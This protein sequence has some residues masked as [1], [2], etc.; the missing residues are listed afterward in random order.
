M[1]YKLISLFVIILTSY[2][3]KAQNYRQNTSKPFRDL[4]VLSL[5]TGSTFGVTDYNKTKVG[6]LFLGNID[7]YF[8][9]S[10]RIIWSIGLKGSIN[11]VKGIGNFLGFPTNFN[12]KSFA[13]GTVFRFNYMLSESYFPYLSMGISNYRFN[14]NH[15]STK[16]S[17]VDAT[18]GEN[19]TSIVF[20]IESG[21]KIQLSEF[22]GLNIGAG[23]HF[24][25][26]DNLDAVAFGKH[27]DYF[28]SGNNGFSISLI[29][30]KDSDGDGILDVYDMC[31]EEAEDFDGYQD[32]DGCPDYDNDHDG[33][34]DSVDNCP[35]T[36][37]DL[38]GYEDSDGCPE[39]DND[40]D[41]ILDKND[42]CPDKAEDFDG[43]KDFDGCPDYDNDKD[44]IPDSL[45]K[46]PNIPEN[47]NGYQDSD[48][49][50]DVK[51]YTKSKRSR[52]KKKSLESLPGMFLLHG[53]NTFAGETGIIKSIAYPKINRI[54][55][56]IKKYP[57]TK[58][59]IE[60]HVDRHENKLKA[61][62]ISKQQAVAIL[63]YFISKGLPPGN[64]EVLG[65]GDSIPISTN[66]T[67]YG[68]L[69]NRR[70]KIIR[71]K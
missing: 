57:N 31:P 37:E 46:C 40:A 13:I 35:Y 1:K 45:D 71:V 49:C 24:I 3:I 44:G 23:I 59:R 48:G 61:R 2:Q 5:N 53:G 12:S 32:D 26:R 56:V 7:Y 34:P 69:K 36:Q 47:F 38:D 21:L 6:F 55:N 60:G 29:Q 54:I 70:I 42:N 52:N 20:D 33:I 10:S 43:Y 17:L 41:G 68:R 16:S 4:L 27:N 67:A 18:A 19:T 64:F 9:T 66:S 63:D 65:M 39:L 11:E 50:P 30:R 25:Q 15:P 22:I 58:W 62:R 28:V 51:P 8:S 14:Y